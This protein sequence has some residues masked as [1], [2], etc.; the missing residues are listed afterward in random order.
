MQGRWAVRSL[1]KQGKLESAWSLAFGA[2]VGVNLLRSIL[3]P[4][5]VVVI[6]GLGLCPVRNGASLES[7]L[8]PEGSL[9]TAGPG[10]RVTT[11]CRSGYRDGLRLLRVSSRQ[12][13]LVLRVHES[14]RVAPHLLHSVPTP[15]IHSPRPVVPQLRLQKRAQCHDW[16]H[17]T[18][19]AT[20]RSVCS[21]R[22]E[23]PR[24]A[25]S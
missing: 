14:Y 25:F 18:A 9:E 21:V 20:L 23:K 5:T 19:T 8:P 15:N 2:S 7:L 12:A 4:T 17:G 1:L 10:M 11:V 13:P 22:A 24:V 16:E 3:P 6:V